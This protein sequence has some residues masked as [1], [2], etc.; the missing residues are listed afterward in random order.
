NRHS[1]ADRG[2]SFRP[3][4]SSRR[5]AGRPSADA[6]V[7]DEQGPGGAQASRPARDASRGASQ[8]KRRTRGGSYWLTGP[9]LNAR[10]PS[11]RPAP[12][13]PG[14]SLDRAPQSLAELFPQSE[15]VSEFASRDVGARSLAPEI[16]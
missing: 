12:G 8:K 10:G 11:G 2:R 4:D 14:P 16:G 7:S 6:G 13:R 1:P 5:R 15:L 9:T 3:R